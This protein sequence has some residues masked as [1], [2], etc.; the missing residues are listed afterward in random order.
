MGSR[1]IIAKIAE[2]SS[3]LTPITNKQGVIK[4]CLDV[5]HAP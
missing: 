4:L 2:N 3:S 1:I 5:S